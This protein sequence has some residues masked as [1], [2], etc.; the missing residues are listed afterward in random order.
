MSVSVYN[1][2]CDFTF[3]D[4]TIYMK[5]IFIIL[6][7][8]IWSVSHAQFYTEAQLNKS[9]DDGIKALDLGE[10][11]LAD[12]LFRVVLE[13]KK[14]LPSELAYYFGKN[15]Y[16]NQQYKQSINWLSKYVQ[17]KGSR[18]LY[19]EDATKHLKL[20]EEAYVVSLKSPNKGSEEEPI[21][22]SEIVFL[23][24][25]ECDSDS[26]TCPV[27]QG[28]GAIVIDGKYE[29]VYKTCPYSGL[30]GYMSCEEYNL[31]INGKLER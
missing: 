17:L 18:G 27:C 9:L 11:D 13:N 1:F 19:F 28:S 25:I 24:E 21:S 16:Y 5:T 3:R 14:V 29:K 7:M 12:S 30:K 2:N 20:A 31:F 22:F 4:Y 8:C 26:V 10:N 23:N 15:S 6:L